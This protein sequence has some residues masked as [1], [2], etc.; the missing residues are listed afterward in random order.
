[1]SVCGVDYVEPVTKGDVNGD[2][3]ITADDARTALRASA[4]LENLN[5]KEKSAADVN[6]DG[7]VTA[8]DARSIL[9]KSAKLE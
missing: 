6:G 7:K 9:R 2:G 3:K 1:M 8:D 5:D 4:K